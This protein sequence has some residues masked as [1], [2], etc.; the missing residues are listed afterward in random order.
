[1]AS[2]FR[3]EWTEA[4]SADLTGIVGYIAKDSP[5]NAAKVYQR[6]RKRAIMLRTLPGRGHP[7][8]ELVQLEILS[9]RELSVPPYRII[10]RIGN[11]EV[12]VHAVLDGRRDLKQLLA[13]RL[14]RTKA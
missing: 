3:V 14:L 7:V 2:R 11:Q 10:Y 6:I 12:F 13:E 5:A 8:P 9:Y 4:A 1:M